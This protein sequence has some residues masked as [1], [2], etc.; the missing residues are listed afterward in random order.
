[1]RYSIATVFVLISIF[2]LSCQSEHTDRLP[3]KSVRGVVDTTGFAHLAWQMDSVMVRIHAL[4]QK[5]LDRTEQPEGTVWKTAICPHDDYTYTG[6]FY[7]AV[8]RN[9]TAKTVIIFGVAH[10]AREFNLENQ[11]VFDSFTSWHGP[12]GDV[13]VS[14]LREDLINHL[15]KEM[16]VVH[17]SMQAIE[18]SVEALIPFL[19]NQ[20][21]DV[22]IVSI[23]V[24]YMNFDRMQKISD[25]LAKALHST[26][27]A[28]NLKWGQDIALLIT[29]DAVH[30]GDEDWG[31]KNYARFGTDSSGN[32]RAVAYEHEIIKSSFDG[33]LTPAKIARFYSYTI[34]DDNFKEYKW[35]WCGRYSI[36]FGLFTSVHLQALENGGRLTGV[37]V[38]YATSITQPHIYVDDLGMGR[39]GIA[40]QRHWVGYPAIGFK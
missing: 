18:H 29:S 35:T 9:I 4:S 31:G 5:D 23:L 10:K 33:E 21:R 40:T 27:E 38:A 2:L 28:K 11:I 30:Y 13:K 3:E 15:P 32:A 12:Y 25:H 39:T 37:P 34:M 24:P 8:L 26:M 19:Q 22:E 14:A 16:F 17:D 36:P 1:M 20:N 6:W 7:P